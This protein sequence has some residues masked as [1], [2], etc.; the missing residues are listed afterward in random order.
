V[1]E[2][3]KYEKKMGR[4]GRQRMRKSS[5]TEGWMDRW[6]K[7]RGEREEAGYLC[8]RRRKCY[9]CGTGQKC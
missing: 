4:E 6:R 9:V 2:R 7:G 5:A 8:Y 1:E 3:K